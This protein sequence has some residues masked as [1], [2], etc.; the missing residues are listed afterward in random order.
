MVRSSEV[1]FDESLI[2]SHFIM[3]G[4]QALLAGKL[5][6]M[7]GKTAPFVMPGFAL[8]RYRIAR[9]G[10]LSLKVSE[11]SYGIH[12]HEVG[13]RLRLLHLILGCTALLFDSRNAHTFFIFVVRRRLWI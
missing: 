4:T 12:G 7:E 2:C 10:Y 3:G 13:D 8:A 11:A 5:V 1:H 9:R 6:L